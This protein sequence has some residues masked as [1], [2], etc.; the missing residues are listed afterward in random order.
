MERGGPFTSDAVNGL[1][2][3]IGER[4]EIV[5]VTVDMDRHG[6]FSP[7]RLLQTDRMGAIL[8]ERALSTLTQQADEE[9]F[10]LFL[11]GPS[12]LLAEFKMKGAVVEALAWPRQETRRMT[13]GQSALHDALS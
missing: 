11:A 5:R 10:M 8:F 13:C 12:G 7:S 9:R 4:A 2:K 1:I 6:M 3:R